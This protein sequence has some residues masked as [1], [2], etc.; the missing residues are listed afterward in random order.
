M[1]ADAIQLVAI[2]MRKGPEHL[3]DLVGRLSHWLEEH[4]YES[5]AQLNGNMSLERCPDPTAYE[6]ANYVQLLQ[7]HG[8]SRS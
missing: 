1:P 8:N 6:R 4:E 3:A 5:L 7:G 2:L